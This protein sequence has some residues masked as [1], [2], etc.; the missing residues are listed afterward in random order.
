ME[1]K[2]ADKVKEKLK[3]NKEKHKEQVC[4]FYK[5]LLLGWREV[6]PVEKA[7]TFCEAESPLLYSG[8]IC[9]YF[10]LKFLL[11]RNVWR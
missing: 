7:I 6:K 2:I 5:I 1:T 9:H 3:A 11:R 4:L 8:R 10:K